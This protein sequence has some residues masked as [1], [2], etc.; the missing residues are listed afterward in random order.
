[1]WE[2]TEK[3]MSVFDDFARGTVDYDKARYAWKQYPGL[4]R[5]A[6]AG[7]LDAVSSHLSEG[8]RANMPD[9]MLTQIDFLLGFNGQLQS[10]VSREFVAR[11]EAL[12]E[13]EKEKAPSGGGGGALELP[14]A[15]ET[16]TQRLANARKGRG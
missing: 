11:I 6:Q 13:A 15:E 1:M 3:P 2:A 4:Q 12:N 5:A 10:T 16:F 7:F 14:A 8:E 9:R